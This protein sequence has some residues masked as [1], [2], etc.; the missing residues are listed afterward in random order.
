MLRQRIVT[1]IVGIPAVAALVYAG[2]LWLFGLA[3]VLVLLGFHEYSRL[4]AARGV[5]VPWRLGA[6]GCLLLLAWADYLARGVPKALSAGAAFGWAGWFAAAPSV[7]L[8]VLLVVAGAMVYQVL[9]FDEMDFTG[10]AATAF[11]VLY[12]GLGFGH[13]ILLRT[14]AYFGS[15]TPV[16]WGLAPVAL[17]FFTTWAADTVAYWAG[18]RFGK[19]KLAPL[20]SPGKTWEGGIAGAL[21]ASLVGLALAPL[22]GWDRPLGFV[23]GLT[24]AVAGAFGDLAESALKRHCGVKDS[25]SILPGHGGV[26]DRFDSSLFVL[27]LAYYL[28]LLLPGSGARLP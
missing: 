14:A 26:L 6:L 19:H 17:A 12:L 9:H 25:G 3:A 10:T 11:G 15:P 8:L 18:L 5:R 24:L 4:W 27:P 28:V 21:A 2:D 20:V 22:L 13:L 16:W 23:A 7:A 1:A